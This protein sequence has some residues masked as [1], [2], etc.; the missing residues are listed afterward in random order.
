MQQSITDIM[1]RRLFSINNILVILIV[2]CASL[3]IAVAQETKTQIRIKVEKDVNG[4]KQIID[5]TFTDPNDPEL[6]ELLK[7][8]EVDIDMKIDESDVDIDLD[9]LKDKKGFNIQLDTDDEESIEQFKQQV[10]QLA[11]DMDIDI[12]INDADK[13]Q[14]K[15]FKYKPGSDDF[16]MDK[17]FEN[18]DEDV[19]QWLDTEQLK[20]NLNGKLKEWDFDIDN[21]GTSNKAIMGVSIADDEAGVVIQNVTENLGAEKAGLQEGD[22]I[23]EVDDIEMNTVDELIDYLAGKKAG[24]FV[25]V[26]YERNGKS[27]SVDVELKTSKKSN[28]KMFN[29]DD[30]DG[31]HKFK[32]ERDNDEGFDLNNAE[33]WIE[34]KVENINGKESKTRVMVMISD[35]EGS[36]IDKLNEIS[37]NAKLEEMDKSEI[38]DLEF[39]PNPSKGIFNLKFNSDEPTNTQI[40]IYNINGEEI[41]NTELDNFKGTF[42]EDIDISEHNNGAYI[43]EI[44]KGNKRMNKKVVIK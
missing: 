24:D 3:T 1:T 43:L 22:I 37:P 18:L 39:F 41:Y 8:N 16:D 17:L 15:M 32:F 38:G 13:K 11:D 19:K 25:D 2:V 30:D 5:K 29:F 4:E 34:E 12:D 40:N 28:L 26:E 42:D 31:F 44:I 27:G 21:F 7:D 23:K 10:E 6:K 20:E 14:L 9:I 35:L 36:D 33:K